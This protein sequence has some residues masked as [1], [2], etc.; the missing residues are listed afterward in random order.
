MLLDEKVI[1]MEKNMW[2]AFSNGDS[3]TFVQLVSNEAIMI[4]G[5]YKTSG[6]EY[7]KL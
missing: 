4:C 2:E 5:G 6:A 7:E 3:T 1:N